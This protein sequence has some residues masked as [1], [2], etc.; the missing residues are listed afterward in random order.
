LDEIPPEWATSTGTLQQKMDVLVQQVT[1]AGFEPAWLDLTSPDTADLGFVVV[2]AFVAGLHPL[3][4]GYLS[5]QTDPRRIA[6]FAK[7]CGVDWSGRIEI[8]PPHAFP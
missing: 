1:K 8:D 4:A 5:P 7:Y 3:S 6:Q 2:K